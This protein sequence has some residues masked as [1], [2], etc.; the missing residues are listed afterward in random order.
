MEF[1]MFVN[2][3]NLLLTNVIEIIIN[4]LMELQFIIKMIF[5]HVLYVNKINY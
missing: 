3:V 1:Q 5:K 2:N 4:K